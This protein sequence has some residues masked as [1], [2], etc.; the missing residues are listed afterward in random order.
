MEPSRNV[1]CFSYNAI[2]KSYKEHQYFDVVK[3]KIKLKIKSPEE[4]GESFYDI[5][6]IKTKVNKYNNNREFIDD[7]EKSVRQLNKSIRK[8]K[9]K[10][11]M[12]WSIFYLYK[13][14]LQK[15]D[16]FK[17][18]RGQCDKW[19]MLP[20]ILRENTDPNYRDDFE[21]IYQSIMYTYPDLIEYYGPVVDEN[22]LN[23]REQVLA[24]LQHYGLKTSLVDITENPFIAML[25]MTSDVGKNT[26]NNATLDLYQINFD[27]HS[28]ENIFS[29]VKMLKSNTR[30]IAQKGAFFNFDKLAIIN[31]TSNVKKIPLIRIELNYK[32]EVLEN[33][34]KS[35]SNEIEKK[36]KYQIKFLNCSQI[37]VIIIYTI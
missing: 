11:K 34:E 3:L 10:Y 1:K 19:K 27:S 22:I 26:F 36:K 33:K 8:H 32:F 24:H 13:E 12:R 23:F 21:L 31:S 5:S 14:I 18:Y 28:K 16:N 9:A 30:I 4:S 25:F 7:V 17:Y 29:R 15:F 37:I 2:A 20:G 6:K 35:L